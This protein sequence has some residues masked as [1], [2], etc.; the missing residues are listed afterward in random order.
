MDSK[1]LSILI[2]VA[3]VV[4][5]GPAV[6]MCYAMA[7]V[8]FFEDWVVWFGLLHLGYSLAI[9][10]VMRFGNW[11]WSAREYGLMGLVI[12]APGYF[13]AGPY[14]T[15]V[16]YSAAPE[17]VRLGMLLIFFLVYG[18]ASHKVAVAYAALFA[19]DSYRREVFPELDGTIL[20]VQQK[21]VE[22]R[23]KVGLRFESPAYVIIA[24]GALCVVA[25]LC[26]NALISYFDLGIAPI[27][28]GILG[29]VMGAMF[30]SAATMIV[31]V[32]F[33]FARRLARESGKPV[34]VSLV[35]VS[36]PPK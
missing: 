15:I 24:S 5:D 33:V 17:L 8:G 20:Y 11:S 18:F 19:D 16:T 30:V 21:D 32:S 26:R 1:D 29:L 9:A 34:F 12:L 23:N 25:F 10:G 35:M 36:H 22:F 6:L 31:V 13:L 4:I 28:V 3:G 14:L 2:A 7:N 27:V